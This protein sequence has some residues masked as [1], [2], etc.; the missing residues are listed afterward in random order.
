MYILAAVPRFVRGRRRRPGGADSALRPRAARR[1]DG[2][3]GRHPE[4]LHPGERLAILRLADAQGQHAERGLRVLLT[5]AAGRPASVLV[6]AL[7]APL[8][9]C[10]NNDTSSSMYVRPLER[11]QFD[12]ITP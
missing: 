12:F 9:H 5:T 1:V 6:A 2:R 4:R 10:N 7:R 3:G 8:H 11:K